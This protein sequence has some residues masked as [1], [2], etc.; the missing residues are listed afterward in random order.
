[1]PETG[2]LNYATTRN[3]TLAVGKRIEEE[4]REE[5]DHP[6]KPSSYVRYNNRSEHSVGR[7]ASRNRIALTAPG[8]PGHFDRRSEEGANR[9]RAISTTGKQAGDTQ[10]KPAISIA[11]IGVG[12]GAVPTLTELLS[13]I[14]TQAG[15]QDC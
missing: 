7:L 5:I 9:K 1:L 13:R 15:G 12:A 2:S 10:S 6:P 3:R 8:K 14:T 11:G 4:I